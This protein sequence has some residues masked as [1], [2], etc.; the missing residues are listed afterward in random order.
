MLADFALG[1]GLHD[2]GAW[3]SGRVP[4]TRAAD[5][6][7]ATARLEEA[8]SYYVPYFLCISVVFPLVFLLNGFYT[9]SRAYIGRYKMVVVMR[10]AGH[11]HPYAARRQLP[12]LPHQTLVPAPR[13]CCSSR[14]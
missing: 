8:L 1:S 5:S 7:A 12:L 10:G 6:V 4:A 11:R 2:R 14:C 9:R 3:H 13:T